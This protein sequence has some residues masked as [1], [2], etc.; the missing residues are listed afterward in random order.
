MQKD[1]IILG[2]TG[3]VGSKALDLAR[4]LNYKIKALVAGK[5]KDKLLEQA[6]L[7]QPDFIVVQEVS[8][9]EEIK[10]KIPD[11]KVLLGREGALEVI[12]T[13][14]DLILS[15]VPGIQ[16][17]ELTLAAI[18]TC[19]ILA[20]A[21]KEALLYAG[22]RLLMEAKNHATKI[23]P[24][25]SEHYALSLLL[26]KTDPSLI[27]KLIITASGGPFR[28]WSSDAIAKASLE[29]VLNHP[30]WK[31]GPKITVDS[32]SLANKAIEIIEAHYLFD[33]P[34]D[35][36]EALVHKESIVHAMVELQ[37]GS[38]MIEASSPDMAFPISAALSYPKP[39][40]FHK[41]LSLTNLTFQPIDQ[42]KFPL[43]RLFLEE[44]KKGHLETIII[45]YI[46]ELAVEKLLAGKITFASLYGVIVDLLDKSKG[47][48]WFLSRN[49]YLEDLKSIFLEIKVLFDQNLK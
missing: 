15:A 4:T 36:I 11:S 12:A 21:N 2:S 5:N 30:T 3:S 6:L 1:I 17:L 42:E 35:K 24:I 43:F 27:Q 19:K 7:S 8:L 13:G 26:E 9:F 29:E 38:L 34:L 48:N 16:G 40:S 45:N 49:N 25:D 47:R 14:A 37:D 39:S 22:P 46:N 41:K 33:Y 32:A 18:K 31:M 44:G 20:L 28:D 10:N 23:L